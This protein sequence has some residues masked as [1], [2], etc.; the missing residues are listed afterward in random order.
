MCYPMLGYTRI[1]APLDG[2]VIQ[3]NVDTGDLPR[4]GADGPRCSSSP[5]PTS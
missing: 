3:R 5:A 1:E 2:V 4:P